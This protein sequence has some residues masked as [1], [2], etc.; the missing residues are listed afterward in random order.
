ML[1]YKKNMMKNIK[2][3]VLALLGVF[4][5]SCNDEFLD[6]KP[7]E[8]ISSEN[9]FK[10]PALAS[11]YLNEVY[12]GI[13]DGFNR[14]WYMLD[15]ASDDAENAYSWAASNASFNTSSIT[16]ANSPFNG[17]WGNSYRQIRRINEFILNYN[18]LE[19]GANVVDRLKG[20]AHFLRAFYYAELL[21]HFG[22]VPIIKVPQNLE[23]DDLLVT[24]NTRLETLDFIVEELDA[25]IGFFATASS[26][27]STRASLIG[28]HAL[29]GRV[30]L[31]EGRYTESA[32]A[33]KKALDIKSALD[34]NYQNIFLDD[35][36]D[37]VI[38]DKQF[39][40]PDKVHYGNLF[41][42]PKSTRGIS[43]WGGTNP[44]QNLV[45][46]YEMK[47][48]GKMITDVT[49]GYDATNPYEGRDPRFYASILYDGAEYYGVTIRTRPG[50]TEHI[51]TSGDWTKTGYSLKKLIQN[52][53]ARRNSG[54]QHWVFMRVAEVHLNYAEALIEAGTSL[55][56]AKASIDMVRQRS[57]MPAITLSGQAEMRTKVRHERRIELAFEEHRF[58]DLRRWKI[59]GD[60]EVLNIYRMKMDTNGN[61]LG[62]DLW[63]T[64][65]WKDS[66]YLM[67]IPQSEMDKNKNLTQNKDY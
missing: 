30:L 40:D 21:K 24:R 57:E 58:W 54:T 9:I 39:K 10:D 49:S 27:G 66:H 38:F 15:A 20:E 3:I 33:S 46:Q 1:N 55:G 35:D 59:A 63:E 29:K 17:A 60:P 67:P 25:A 19:G 5:T 37:E 47:A 32:A 23:G 53:Q 12:Q 28:S 51:D 42:Y 45:D 11:L 18:D 62:K 2:I 36:T 44:T 22:G 6:L 50:G 41:N 43:G 61:F 16:P 48:T 13:P 65:T 56:L 31:Y 14:G 4:I 7:L 8:S 52:D 34:A 64:R 26:A